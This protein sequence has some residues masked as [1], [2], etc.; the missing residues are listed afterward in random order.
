MK[1]MQTEFGSCNRKEDGMTKG[2]LTGDLQSDRLPFNQSDH[3]GHLPLALQMEGWDGKGKCGEP[4]CQT[5]CRVGG[6]WLAPSL[7]RLYVA[8]AAEGANRR[9][10]VGHSR[11]MAL[12]GIDWSMAEMASYIGSWIWIDEIEEQALGKT[13]TLR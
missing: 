10:G 6:Q 3:N 11:G 4:S 2:G 12:R 7:A 8:S 5:K 13:I 1:L 9:S